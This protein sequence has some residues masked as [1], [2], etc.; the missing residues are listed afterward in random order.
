MDRSTTTPP[1]RGSEGRATLV[2]LLLATVVI[3]GV[4]ALPW[5]L[6]RPAIV[7]AVLQEFAQRTGHELSAEAWHV[8]IF[9]SIGLELVHVQVRER[10]STT[11]LFVA[12][13]LEMALQ[14]LPLLEGR[15]VGKDLIID[16]PRLTIRRGHTGTWSI[17]GNGSASSPGDSAPPFALLQAV[18]SLLV[19][20]GRITI[21]DESGLTLRTPIQIIVTQGTLSSE[22][23]GRHARLQVSGEIPQE[24]DS[25]AFT[26]DGSLTQSQNGDGMHAEGDLRLH[27]ID[28]RQL[29]SV[30]A[31]LDPVSDGLV[32][33]AQLTA[34]LRW[35]PRAEGSDLT[36]DEWKVELS[37]ISVQGIAAVIGVG[38][39]HPHFSSTLS[40]P[41]VTLTRLLSQTPSAW[42]SPHLRG[43]LAE[44]GVDGL[45]T[46]QSMS[47]SGELASGSRPNISGLVAIRNGR[48]TLDPQYPSIEAL[49]GR[50]SYD[51][52][53]VRMIDLRAQCGPVRLTG[54]DLLI[55]QWLSE[56]HLD[57]K[58]LGTAPATGLLDTARRID[59]FPLL[60]NILTQ[61]EQPTGDVE[62]VAHVMGQPTGG[63]PLALVD[64][65]FTLHHVGF[66]IS[67]FSVPVQQVQARINATPTVVTLERLE[68]RLGPARFDARGA[69]TLME[70]RPHSDVKLNM[71]MD[72]SDVGSL[73]AEGVDVGLHPEMDGIIRMQAALTGPI[74]ESRL[75]GKVDL[76]SAALRIPNRL[77]KPLQAPAALE[78]DS[79]LSGGNRLVVRHFDLHV[80][81]IKIAGDGTIDLFGDMDF[82]ANVSSGAVSVSRLPAGVALGPIRTGTLDVAL[83]MEGQA[84]VRASWRTSGE[85]RVDR[86]TIN[87]EGLDEPIRN[88]FMTLRFDQDR[89]Q[90]ARMAFQVGASDLRVSGS[91]AH[92]A[93]SPKARLVVES[94]QIDVAAFSSSPRKPSPSARDRSSEKPWWLDGT[95]EAFFFADYVYYKKFLLT[96]LSSRIVWDH[97]LLTV[98]RISGDTNEG[99]VAGQVKVREA[100]GRLEQAGGTFRVSG[101][102]IERLLALVQGKP[103]MTGWLTTSGKLQAEF[104]R[105]G[106]ALGAVT[107]RQP[108]QILVEDGRIYNVPVISTL[109]SVM[110]LPALL[111]GQVDL[112]KDGLPL[113]RMKLVFSIN[114]GV[115]NMKEFLLDSPILKISGTGRYDILADEFDMVLATS[116]LGSYSAML[117]RIPLFGQLLAG[118]RQ[119][120]DTAVFELKGSAN[121]PALR[122]L[123]VES[124]MTGVKG[125]AQLAFDILVNAISLPHKAFSM[126]EEGVAGGDAEEF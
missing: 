20:G 2:F 104:E 88:A 40:A 84:K 68:G 112:D 75:K 29:V 66:R 82:A 120:F 101:I 111:Q 45:I 114:N 92:W 18:R 51:A 52:T 123:P 118:D 7:E 105:T 16:R 1:A 34:H 44:H 80:P 27:H 19:V 15:V 54:E 22:I 14:F 79:Q 25:A 43:R 78:F 85:V 4:L 106:L 57:V 98:E 72:A 62:M 116:P 71:S 95:L 102:P 76:Q 87:M 97:G 96:D 24:R 113:D 108:I 90:I 48:F 11:P 17:G 13:R 119:G 26:F 30:W 103:V 70:G 61:V 42:I 122:Y 121:K 65:N 33:P 46:V 10:S 8:R 94:S 37:D 36:V 109:L 31:G 28:V 3:A 74:G 38:T 64:I 5:I 125:T 73:L 69:V 86:G 81:P 77:T 32:G 49:S 93:E 83:H 110:N 60:R 100:G 50:I 99:H 59:G 63:K 56:P 55:T 23:M 53:Q 67:Q 124:L 58:I 47:L 41:P 12:D 115:I 39:E 107:S 35:S 117:K 9:P 6:T 91:I 21:I 126:I 89:I